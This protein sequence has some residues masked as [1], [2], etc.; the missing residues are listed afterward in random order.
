MRFAVRALVLCALGA[1]LP[2][3]APAQPAA[4][5]S[6]PQLL[7]RM[8][9]VNG[10][11]WNAHMSST[12]PHTVDGDDA[13]L[14][15]EAQGLRFLLD[16]CN[17]KVCLGTYFDGERLY[18]VNI[19]GT[20]LPRS[21]SPEAYL[22]GLRI[23][24]TLAFLAPDFIA[25]GG[26]IDD[27]GWVT[28]EGKRCRRIFV[29]DQIAIP[30]AIFVDPASGLVA[31]AQDVNGDAT[32]AMHDYRRVG[33]FMLPYDIERN[34]AP[35][36]RYITRKILADPLDAPHGL[37]PR[38]TSMPAGMALDPSSTTPIGTCK[39]AGLSERC[40]IDSGNSALSMSK[41]LAEQLKLEP[42]G[43]M[44]ISGLGHYA[45]GVVRTG[46]LQLGNVTFG[47]ADYVVL[48]DIHQYGYDL[49]VG[50]DVLASMPVT[51]DTA[52]H[53]IFFG[54]QTA[55]ADSTE[56]PLAFQNFVPVV[57]V[58]LGALPTDLAVD[59]GDQSNINL[60]FRYYQEHPNLFHPTK[61]V[62]VSGVGTRSEELIGEI[63]SVRIGG[64]T[65]ENQEIGT[66]KA[67]KG[68]A[69]GH[70]GAGF[71]SKY[72]ITLDYAHQLLKLL[73]KAAAQTHGRI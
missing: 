2:V 24:G 67:L 60:A 33:A 35:L 4:S 61:S 25:H 57:S 1:M 54:A 45:T 27:G 5:V 43:M 37:T 20:A 39:I 72:R 46:P 19:N 48:S 30:M 64:L 52:K 56:V 44:A 28:F 23:I 49:V 31:G 47:D 73:P 29:S 11:L 68:T 58:T 66:T 69:N 12:S 55:V 51:I 59:T 65:A 16:Q 53:A 17:V 6:L 15:T 63:S 7:N 32:Y 36:E 18:S 34:G 21:T 26:R 50:A 38:I 8:R 10:G 9:E 14:D 42:I 13:I 40:L 3:L 22:R 41:E 62:V 71:L 70:L